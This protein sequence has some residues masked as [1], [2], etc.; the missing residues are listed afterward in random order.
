[1]ID[2]VFRTVKPELS[3][4]IGFAY[5]VSTLFVCDALED[6][7][8]AAKHIVID[9]CQH[10]EWGGI[11]LKNIA[12]AG[13]EHFIDF[14]EEGS[15]ITLPSLMARGTRV[16]A[17]IIDGAHTFDHA[18][19]DFFYINKMLTVGG[20]IILDDTDFRSIS[21]LVDHIITYPAYE[22][23]AT[24]TQPSRVRR[25][26]ARWTQ[27]PRL[28]RERDATITNDKYPSCMA[29]RKIADDNRRW[30]WHVDF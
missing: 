19:V 15:E 20:I 27:L 8:R 30:D 10:S 22:L 13:Y 26:L 23:F 11:G 9:P 1:M 12:R 3:L 14:R 6:N 17:A 18:L 25:A 16:K 29:F 4:E 28:R 5:G 2:R 21:Q 24:T 7:R